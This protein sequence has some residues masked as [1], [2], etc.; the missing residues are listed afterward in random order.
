MAYVGLLIGGIISIVGIAI[1]F[2]LYMQNAGSTLGMA[3][4]F[5]HVHDFLFHKW[6]FDE[7]IDLLIVRPVLAMGRFA[8]DVF[9]RVVV[10]GVVRVATGGVGGL[11]AAV[12]GAQSGFVR[13]YALLVLAGLA[14]LGAYFLIV[15]G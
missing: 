3:K 12:R 15:S 10:D 9:E 6:Y 8:N 4:R 11:S 13:F 7:I 5:R 14:G 2:Y 1:A